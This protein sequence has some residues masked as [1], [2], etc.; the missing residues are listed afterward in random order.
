ML[1]MS[2]YDRGDNKSDYEYTTKVDDNFRDCG[3]F[4][5]LFWRFFSSENNGA[6]PCHTLVAVK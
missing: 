4:D 5:L 6:A 3:S 2:R 1:E